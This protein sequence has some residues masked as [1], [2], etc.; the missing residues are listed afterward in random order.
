MQ[1]FIFSPIPGGS[2]DRRSDFEQKVIDM[3]QA[4]LEPF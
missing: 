3:R 4:P 1:S 2:R